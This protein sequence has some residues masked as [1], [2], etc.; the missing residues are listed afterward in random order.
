MTPFGSSAAALVAAVALPVA[1]RAA[2]Q[3]APPDHRSMPGMA[4]ARHR[5]A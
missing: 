5:A 3:T 2:D 4:P 1:A